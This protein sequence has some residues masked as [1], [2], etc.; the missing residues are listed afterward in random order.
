MTID[1]TELDVGLL[2]ITQPDTTHQI[3]YIQIDPIQLKPT[4]K[5]AESLLFCGTATPGLENLGL[6]TPN[7][8]LLL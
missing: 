5:D 1:L 3:V 8:T 4:Y 7:L 2:L 6:Q